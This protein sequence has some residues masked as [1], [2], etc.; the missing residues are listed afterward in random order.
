MA[1]SATSLHFLSLTPQSLSFSKPNA[2]PA[3]SLSLFSL[4]SSS[5]ALKLSS[6]SS[7]FTFSVRHFDSTFASR[8]VRG[9]TLSS[10]FDQIEE[11][12]DEDEGVPSDGGSSYPDEPRFSPELKLFV[13]NL[14]YN[15]DSAALAGLFQQAG[16]VEM[17]EVIYDK[18]TGR[19]RG[20]G[21]V[22]MSTVEEV[23]LAAQQFNGYEL[24]GRA[25][26][27][28][29]GPPPPRRENST[30]GGARGGRSFDN[31]N[32]GHKLHVGNLAWGVDDQAL[33]TLFS[34]QGKVLE[35]RVVYDR[36]SG[37]SRGFGFVTYGSAEEANNAIK[38]LDGVN[39]IGRQIGV[40]L[41]ESRPPRRQF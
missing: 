13:G 10:E 7:P 33:E 36:E 39:L 12:E 5:R 18:Q 41:A 22:T 29:S 34:E 21:F 8:F 6:S 1:T 17:V 19:S 27:V 31:A 2:I 16:N 24:D 11:V 4:P 30:F 38:M 23:E 14:P 20:F 15:I 9:V 28:N 32:R 3:A 35:A 37:R 40:S 26:K 25:L